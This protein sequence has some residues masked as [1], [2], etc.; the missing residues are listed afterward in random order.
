MQQGL[1]QGIEQQKLE[2]AQNM[3]KENIDISLISKITNLSLE[4]I[5]KLK[6]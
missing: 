2:I 6:A 3:L 5:T 4:T 1:E